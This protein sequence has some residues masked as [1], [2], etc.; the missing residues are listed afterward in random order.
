MGYT[1]RDIALISVFN[2]V[3]QFSGVVGGYVIDNHGPTKASYVS[4]GC[5]FFGYL[6]L[7][8]QVMEHIPSSLGSLCVT[9]LVAQI[10]LSCVAQV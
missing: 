7:W 1:T 10:G 8:L 3:G 5:F 9:M 4:G 2:N 6:L